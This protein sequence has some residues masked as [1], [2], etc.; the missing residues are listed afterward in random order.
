MNIELIILGLVGITIIITAGAI[1]EDIREKISQNSNVLGKLINCPMCTGFWV[2]FFFGFA[3]GIAPPIIVGGLVS[4]LSWSTYSLVDYFIT[5]GTWYAT[6]I[7][8]ETT[9][10]TNTEGENESQ[11]N[12]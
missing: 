8:K 2:G 7:V 6:Q 12:E 11:Q 1:F 4:L 9:T 5:K 10:E 3:S